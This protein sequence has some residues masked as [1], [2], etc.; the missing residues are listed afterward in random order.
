VSF[1]HNPKQLDEGV[2]YQ[3]IHPGLLVAMGIKYN[4]NYIDAWIASCIEYAQK[5]IA[6]ASD[7]SVLMLIS[8]W[9]NPEMAWKLDS[10]CG[11]VKK[12]GIQKMMMAGWSGV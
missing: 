10:A 2:L 4:S 8:D 12:C 3:V 5:V 9:D 11:T 1:I 7:K 6:K